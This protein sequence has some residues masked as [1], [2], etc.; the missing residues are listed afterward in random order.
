MTYT[1]WDVIRPL[2]LPPG[3]TY[4]KHFGDFWRATTY[5]ELEPADHLVNSGWCLAQPGREYVVFEKQA[6]PFTL[7]ITGAKSPLPAA[8]FNPHTGRRTAAGAVANGTANFTPP[9]NWGS[10]PLVLHLRAP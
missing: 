4:L 8:W 1:A 9:T 2:D 3:Y 6:Q 10:A 7:Q 5:W